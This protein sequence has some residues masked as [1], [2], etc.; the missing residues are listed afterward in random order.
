MLQLPGLCFSCQGYVSSSAMWEAAQRFSKHENGVIIH[1]GDHDPSGIDMSRDI[2]S[3]LNLFGAAVDIE[4]IALNLDQIEQY[5]PPPNP[6]KESD[7]RASGY[8]TR[9]GYSSWE[10]NSLEPSVLH[11]LICEHIKP[12]IDFGLFDAAKHRQEQDRQKIFD[13]R[14]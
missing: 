7:K 1:L 8:I 13:I 6:A 3:R 14:I 4:R 11:N 2:Q 12:L 5:K 10:L 9:Y